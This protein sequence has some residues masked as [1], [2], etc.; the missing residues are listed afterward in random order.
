MNCFFNRKEPQIALVV[1]D[2]TGFNYNLSESDLLLPI[3]W[4][5]NSKQPVIGA[6]LSLTSHAARPVA[7]RPTSNNMNWPAREDYIVYQLRARRVLL[8]YST[9]F[10]WEPEGSYHC[11]T[12]MVIA[13]I[14]FSTEHC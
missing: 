11:T 7:W 5:Q 3:M 9:M 6:W 4:Y 8:Y 14:W 12:S 2:E 1:F 13:P 10:Y